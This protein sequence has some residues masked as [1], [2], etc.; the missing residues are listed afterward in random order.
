MQ[1]NTLK[2]PNSVSISREHV[3]YCTGTIFTA[4]IDWD[5]SC[6]TYYQHSLI[7]STIFTPIFHT[8]IFH[9][10]T[11]EKHTHT[12]KKKSKPISIIFHFPDLWKGHCCG[13]CV[14][15]YQL[16][17]FS[18]SANP[19]WPLLRATWMSTNDTLQP[20]LSPEGQVWDMQR[21]GALFFYSSEATS[22]AYINLVFETVLRYEPILQSS[23]TDYK[24]YL[25]QFA[26]YFV[27]DSPT[28]WFHHC[29]CSF[30]KYLSI[31]HIP[32]YSTEHVFWVIWTEHN[33]IHGCRNTPNSR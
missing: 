31:R 16:P 21:Y 14:W 33:T 23:V 4:G 15:S 9:H 29:E 1:K 17:P 30:S 6:N 25:I 18:P 7:P 19:S 28:A 24:L 5:T 10:C 2:R 26:K 3:T 12:H 20:D 8:Y 22:N 32:I 11:P 13:Q 27:G